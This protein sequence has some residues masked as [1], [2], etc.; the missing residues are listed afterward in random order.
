[1]KKLMY[2]IMLTCK[3][4]TF[5]SSI[6]SFQKLKLIHR[7]QLKL[8]FMVC[9]DCH[10]FDH[11]SQLIDQSMAD[12]HKNNQLRSEEIL[13]EEK[14]SQIIHTVNQHINQ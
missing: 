11:Q 6:K 8:H 1:M 14:K 4:A 10:E 7:I 12:F 3:Q 9:K 5:F 2:K 13:S